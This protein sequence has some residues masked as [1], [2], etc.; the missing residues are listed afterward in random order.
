MARWAS[1]PPWDVEQYGRADS[2]LK[3]ERAA[4]AQTFSAVLESELVPAGYFREYV[5]DTLR[6]LE[7][8]PLPRC[9]AGRHS[10][11]IDASGNVA[12]CIAHAST[13]NLRNL[14][15]AEILRR[16]DHD[17]I[18]ACSDNGSCNL[19]CARVVGSALR[20]PIAGIRELRTSRQ[21]FTAPARNLTSTYN[22]NYYVSGYPN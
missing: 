20:N 18:R 15:L 10:I 2:A 19:L 21:T 1:G 8:K 17:F 9:D 14:P 4:A 22:H 11:A 12:P 7:R 13:G 16:M 6:W 5:R 3:Y